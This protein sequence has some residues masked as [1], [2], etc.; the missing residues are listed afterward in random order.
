MLTMSF[1]FRYRVALQM[2]RN[3]AQKKCRCSALREASTENRD[4]YMLT[5]VSS[6]WR[7]ERRVNHVR[8]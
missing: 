6:D 2:V 8:E 3:G 5:M 4:T 7:Y 1:L